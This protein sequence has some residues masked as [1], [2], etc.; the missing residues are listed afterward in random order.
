MIDPQVVKAHA[1]DDRLRFR[2]AK[3]TRF[4]I[5]RLWPRSDRADFDKTKTQLREPVDG[6]PIFIQTC[7]Q[8][9][10]VREVEAHHRHRQL[11]GRLAQQTVEPQTATR[12]DQVQGQVMRGF[13]GEFEE[14]LAG[15][16]I[17]GLDGLERQLEEPAIIA[18]HRL[19]KREAVTGNKA[20]GS[21]M[22]PSP[23]RRQRKARPKPGFYVQAS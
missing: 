23:N 19:G 7:G 14:Q 16:V 20:Y 10:R 17:H 4:G 15:Q 2:Q 22:R 13:R 18:G 5:A 9:D 8:T 6:R 12:T 3:N 21:K 11:G 1:I